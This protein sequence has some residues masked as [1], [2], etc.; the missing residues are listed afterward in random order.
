[1]TE[2]DPALE[3]ARDEDAAGGDVDRG[4]VLHILVAVDLAP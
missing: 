2:I 4:R 1:M 3:P